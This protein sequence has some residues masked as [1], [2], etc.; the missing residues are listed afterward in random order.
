MI[1]LRRMSAAGERRHPDVEQVGRIRARPFLPSRSARS[2]A[3]LPYLYFL[4]HGPV[5][6]RTV[7]FRM[8]F[9]CTILPTKQRRTLPSSISKL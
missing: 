8:I 6:V 4:L 7:Y 3:R 2:I 1:L 5:R 9:R